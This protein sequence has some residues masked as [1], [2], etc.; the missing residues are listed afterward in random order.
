[1]RS[2]VSVTNKRWSEN[3]N[4]LVAHNGTRKIL[5][6]MQMITITYHEVETNTSNLTNDFENF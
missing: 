5:T 2:R 6:N 4:T 3:Y 1:M